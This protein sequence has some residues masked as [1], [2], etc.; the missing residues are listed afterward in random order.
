MTLRYVLILAA[1]LLTACN[2]NLPLTT[3]NIP[4]TAATATRTAT[5]MVQPLASPTS[6]PLP[7]PTPTDT[8]TATAPLP[9]DTPTVPAETATSPAVT[10]F[11]DTGLYAWQPVAGGLRSPVGLAHAGDGSGRLFVL[12]QYGMIRIVQNGVV[13]PQ[14]YLDIV[15]QVNNEGNEQ[16]LLGLAFHPRYRENGY[17]YINYTDLNGDTVIARFQVSPDDPNRA[18]PASETRLLHIPQPYANHNGGGMEFG[19]DGYLYLG[20]GDGGAAGDPLNNGQSLNS[21][22]GKLLRIDVDQGELYAVPADNPFAN[23]GGLPEIWA[24]GLRNPWRFSFDRL[25][26]DLY[27]GDVGQNQWEEIDYLPANAPGGANFGWNYFEGSHP[28]QGALPPTQVVIAPVAE[29]SHAEGCSVTGGVVYRGARLPDWQGVYLYGDYCT[30]RVWG[31]LRNAEGDWMHT[32]LFDNVGR[33]TSFGEDE[34]GEIY[35]VDRM[36]LI[37]TLVKK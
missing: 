15:S 5:Q 37:Y 35:L 27:I 13:L 31:L 20:L 22:L 9:S 11:P 4:A 24:Y 18:D 30:G 17:F 2:S 3:V 6:I 36:G 8:P 25:T 14:P 16:G 28:Y 26:G 19:P 10:G 7:S 32:V 21:L 34:Q 29:Y 23:G 33:I 1:I 12:E